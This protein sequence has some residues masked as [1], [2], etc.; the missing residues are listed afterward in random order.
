MCAEGDEEAGRKNGSGPWQGVKQ[1]EVG[2]GLG[3]LRNSCIE[4][5][6]GLQRDAELGH[7]GLHQEPIG[8]DDTVI[9]GER[10]GTLDGLE[11]G[12]DAVGSAP[13]TK[14]IGS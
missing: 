10:P 2:M 8:G 13:V 14:A 7:A 5:G 12:V 1:R 11:A 6:N 9:G 4:V 3:A